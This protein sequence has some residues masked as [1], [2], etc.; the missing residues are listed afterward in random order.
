MNWLDL[1]IILFIIIFLVIGLKK[2]F[3][4]SL[5]SNFSFKINALL[6]FFLCK[7]FCI[8]KSK[9]PDFFTPVEKPV[10][11]VK[12]SMFST[13]LPGLCTGYR[14]GCPVHISMYNLL[15]SRLHF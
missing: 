8:R 6:S 7:P 2:G 11:T 9:N 10:E 3:M 14:K 4:T 13:V 5:I 1:G 12:N 15:K